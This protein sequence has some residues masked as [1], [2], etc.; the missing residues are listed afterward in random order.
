MI[1]CNNDSERG[2]GFLLFVYQAG[3]NAQAARAT[4]L[5]THPCFITLSLWKGNLCIV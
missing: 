4:A 5:P 3:H 1:I 2:S